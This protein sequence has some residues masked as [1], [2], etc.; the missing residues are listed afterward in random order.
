MHSPRKQIKKTKKIKNRNENIINN[1]D[2][3]SLNRINMPNNKIFLQINNIIN[4]N[5]NNEIIKSTEISN[6]LK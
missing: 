2:S 6:K 1:N 3:S 4:E 5:K